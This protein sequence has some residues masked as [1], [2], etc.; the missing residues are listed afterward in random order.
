MA[1]FLFYQNSFIELGVMT[2][3]FNP[4]TREGEQKQEDL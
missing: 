4:T 2:W 1:F 3:A